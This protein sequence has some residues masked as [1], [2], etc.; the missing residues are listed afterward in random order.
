M[1]KQTFI[2][3]AMILVLAGLINR[4]LGFIPRMALPRLIGAEGVGLYQMGYPFLI[5]VMTLVTG[6][7]PIAVA[8]LVA[9]AEA[10]GDSVKVK[11]VLITALLLSLALSI[12]LTLLCYYTA[13]WIVSNL[14]TDSRVQL[15]FL[16]MSPILVFV[17]VS[18]VLRG[19]FQGRQNMVPTALSQVLETLFRSVGVLLLAYIMLP[20]GIEYAAAGAMLGVLAGEIMGM[21]ALFW[22]L[23]RQKT[24]PSTHSSSDSSPLQSILHIAFPVTGSKMVGS[25]S[26]FLE[27][28]MIVQSLA[29]AGLTAASATAQYGMLQG[30]VIPILLLPGVLTYS[31]SVSLVP[32]LSEAAARNDLRM[33]HRR[34]HQALRL[35]LVSGA[36]FAVM[37]WVLAEPI[38]IFLYAD[39][40]AGRL[41]RLLTPVALFLY[42]QGPLQAALQALD[43]PGA[44]LL[45][46]FVGATVKLSLIYLLAGKLQW[47]IDGVV[48]A[49]AI[50]IVLVTLLHGRSVYKRTAFKMAASD[51]LKIGS[52]MLLLGLFCSVA[53]YRVELVGPLARFLFCL[54][55]GSALYLFCMFQ[56]KLIDRHDL[57]RL[58]W[59]GTKWLRK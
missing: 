5:A 1:S 35:A 14:L 7:I 41:L 58:P 50:N 10:G 11:K 26:Y 6:G 43:K 37:M 54:L 34:L 46:T 36:P 22:Q 33:I 31:L 12:P 32:A 4:L 48:A 20:L 23:A 45:N 19:Y 8:K 21:L 29:L 52:S 38:C 44:A 3:G 30:M 47:G 49:F 40:E 16:C 56:L 13:P 18:S 59:L 2:K 9:E 57:V 24:A 17:S 55:A 51:F 25:T 53:M 28:I 42:F 39:A 15:T 27:S